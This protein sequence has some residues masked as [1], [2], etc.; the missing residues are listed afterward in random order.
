HLLPI[1]SSI[2]M[3]GIAVVSLLYQPEKKLLWTVS[4]ISVLILAVY[5]LTAFGI[6]VLETGG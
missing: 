6:F 5:L 1:L 4:W 2:L 3:S